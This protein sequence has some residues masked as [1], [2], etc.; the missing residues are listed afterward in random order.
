MTAVAQIIKALNT[1]ATDVSHDLT[2][3]LRST[4][5]RSGWPDEVAQGLSVVVKDGQFHIH[6]P[7]TLASQVEV[8]EHG[9]QETP[10]N[11]VLRR[12]GARIG[13]TGGSMLTKRTAAALT[14]ARVI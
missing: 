13:S 6:Y 10:A 11:P 14:K 7:E 5:V 1:S 2:R 3:G 9:D 4:A 8:L 12:Y